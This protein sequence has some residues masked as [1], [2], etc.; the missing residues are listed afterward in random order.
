MKRQILNIKGVGK[1]RKQNA[2]KHVA[3]FKPTIK[4]IIIY[5]HEEQQKFKTGEREIYF[6][7][8][9]MLSLLFSGKKEHDYSLIYA[10]CF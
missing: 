4:N 2:I 3:S 5:K 6:G 8:Q 9:I 7:L 10:N 1:N